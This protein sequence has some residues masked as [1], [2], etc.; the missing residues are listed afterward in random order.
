MGKMHR[1]AEL[2]YQKMADL[3]QRYLCAGW[4][5]GNEY[6]LW[7]A[8][9]SEKHEYGFGIL[10]QE[11]QK[12]LRLLSDHAGGWIWTGPESRSQPEFVTFPRWKLIVAECATELRR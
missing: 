2:L 8:L 5:R 6:D 7:D 10:R 3:S 9:H 1:S 11:H 4:I 12:E